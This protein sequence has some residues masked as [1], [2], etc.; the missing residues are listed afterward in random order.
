MQI[1]HLIAVGMLILTTAGGMASTD[2]SPVQ[3]LAGSS[4]VILAKVDSAKGDTISFSTIEVLKGKAR[5]SFT[6]KPR[7]VDL[8]PGD[9]CLLCGSDLSPNQG[10]VSATLL[11]GDVDWI[12]LS[13]ST[14]GKTITVD[15][16][17]SLEQVRAT[18]APPKA[19]L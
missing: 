2:V 14:H 16:V 17:G 7:I 4:N 19:K 13:V 15:G 8:K 11:D 1:S 6:L 5:G 12:Y 18:C 3:R 9:E 10:T